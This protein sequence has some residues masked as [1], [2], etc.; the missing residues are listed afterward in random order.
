MPHKRTGSADP[1]QL[2]QINFSLPKK[3]GLS[4]L[5]GLRSKN[6]SLSR[7]NVCINGNHVY[8]EQ[9]EG[10]NETKDS[11]SSS[12]PSPQGFRKKHLFSSTENLAPRSW[13][14]PGEGGA[15]SSDKRLSESSTKNSPKSMTLPSSWLPVSGDIREN[16]APAKSEAVKETKESKKQENRK[17]SLLSLVTGKKDVAKGSEG[18]SPAAPPGKEKEGMLREDGPGPVEGLVKR[19]EEDTTAIISG[20][21][22]SL[23][24][25]E[26]VQITE[27]EADPGPKSDPTPPVTSARAPQTKAVKPR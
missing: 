4:F 10:K 7:S 21:G 3:E 6:D 5:G 11:T 8:V 27:P 18:E 23:N 26:E 20:R 1:K 2:N 19:P 14:E 13:K 22:K 12:S 16:T 15:V 24:P 9:P 17:S 25:F